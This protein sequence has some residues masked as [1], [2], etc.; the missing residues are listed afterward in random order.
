MTFKRWTDERYFDL[1]KVLSTFG[2][3]MPAEMFDYGTKTLKPFENYLGSFLKLWD[4]LDDPKIVEAW[5]AMNT[6]VNDN[7]PMAGGAFRQLIVDLYRNDP[8]MRG[9]WMI[10]GERVNLSR[11]HANLLTFDCGR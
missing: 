9:E 6:W 2:G 8:L 4:N 10:R 11:I 1:D 5:H 3:N 7:I